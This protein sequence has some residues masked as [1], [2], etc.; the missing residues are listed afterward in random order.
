MRHG[1]LMIAFAGVSL[2]VATAAAAAASHALANVLSER[3][4]ASF[5]TAVRLQFY[6]GLGLLALPLLADR[7]GAPRLAGSAGWLFIAGT[8]LF[9][10]AVYVNALGG[11]PAIARVAPAGGIAFIAGWIAVAAAALV[12]RAEKP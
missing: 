2:A 6:H 10:G 8:L 1:K 3:A 9:C 12:G 7:L 4:L 5:E 11:P